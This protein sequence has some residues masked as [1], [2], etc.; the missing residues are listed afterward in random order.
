MDVSEREKSAG[1][2]E[3]LCSQGP[4]PVAAES[5][6]L[7]VDR[8]MWEGMRL[9]NNLQCDCKKGHP[10]HALGYRGT[11]ITSAAREHPA[12]SSSFLETNFEQAFR[13]ALDEDGTSYEV[14]QVDAQT[15]QSDI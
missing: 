3:M 1:P 15:L 2:T 14:S 6:A 5:V 11:P 9:P 12:G 4:K 7:A 13:R 10:H 8:A